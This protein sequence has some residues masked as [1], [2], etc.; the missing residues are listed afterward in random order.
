MSVLYKRMI[1]NTLEKYR[2]NKCLNIEWFMT[3]K[4]HLKNSFIKLI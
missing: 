4:Y 1:N 2:K 3:N